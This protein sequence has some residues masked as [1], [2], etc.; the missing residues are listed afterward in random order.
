MRRR[1]RNH[2][3]RLVAAPLRGRAGRR[4]ACL[5]PALDARAGGRGQPQ[6]RDAASLGVLA[7]TA[8]RRSLPRAARRRSA[9]PRASAGP[10]AVARRLQRAWAAGGPRAA[11]P[12]LRVYAVE[13]AAAAL[14]PARY[15]PQHA[16]A[17]LRQNGAIRRQV[18][19]HPHRARRQPHAA[20]RRGP[21]GPTP[22]GRAR[23][24][25]DAAGQRSGGRPLTL[26]DRRL[27]SERGRR[28]R[29]RAQASRAAGGA[30]PG[31]P[32]GVAPRP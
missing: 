25:G 5:L 13:L 6:R 17:H 28:T 16:A 4:R 7:R 27:G 8:Q 21:D 29:R 1:Q 31:Q 3:A 9:S 19:A 12:A 11:H 15:P 30:H 2:Q 14:Q 20:E 10:H 22:A 32:L 23:G 26:S 24:E 18:R